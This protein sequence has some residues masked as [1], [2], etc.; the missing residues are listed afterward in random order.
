VGTAVDAAAGWLIRA[1]LPDGGWAAP[2][3]AGYPTCRRRLPA[4]EHSPVD[5]VLQ[6]LVALGRYATLEVAVH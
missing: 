3:A 1:Q 5:G 6:P 2:G 4:A